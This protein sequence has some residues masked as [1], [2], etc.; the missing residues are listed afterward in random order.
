MTEG[1]ASRVGPAAAAALLRDPEVLRLW[2]AGAV[3]QCARWLDILSFGVL[4]LEW[5]ASPLAVALVLFVRML[6]LLLF[7]SIAGT[8]AD[9]LDRRRLLVIGLSAICVLLALGTWWSS[10]GEAHLPL[11]FGLAIAGGVLWSGELP[12]RRGLLAEA[13]G[14]DRVGTSMGLEQLTS[15]F[16]RMIGPATGG[17]LVATLGFTGVLA[18]GFILHGLALLMILGVKPSSQAQAKA[19]G[20][21]RILGPLMEGWRYVRTTPILIGTVMVTAAMNLWGFPYMSL[22]PVIAL[23]VMKL[24]PVG[25]G[26]L[27]SAEGAGA[28]IGS[29]AI[30]LAAPPHWFRRIYSLGTLLFLAAV[31]L[32]GFTTTP[33]TAAACTALAGVGMACFGTMQM[34]LI[35]Q[36]AESH[37]RGRALGILVGAMGLAPFGFLQFGL[38]ASWLDG[39]TAV[40]LVAGIG[41]VAVLAC[42]LAWPTLLQNGPV[43]PVRSMYPEAPPRASR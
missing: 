38:A 42:T 13:A 25:T 10:D 39:S 14:M 37:L 28:F 17:A 1:R 2:G 19:T 23:E 22:V 24:G 11:A 6:P 21:I 15:N 18:A 27:V 4:V 36:G 3:I 20:P 33:W 35:L 16:T 8:L 43:T 30:T 7:G 5:T 29:I 9:R 12:M 40:V 26:L 41:L 32:F 31:V 34:V